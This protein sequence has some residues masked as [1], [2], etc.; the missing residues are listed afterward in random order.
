MKFKTN[1]KLKIKGNARSPGAPVQRKPV[2]RWASALQYADLGLAVVPVWGIKNDRCACANRGCHRP[3]K[4]PQ[5]EH[6]VKDATKNRAR[7]KAAWTKSPRSN[8]GVA[9]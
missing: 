5:T 6:G 1:T 3:G 8:I 2:N 4:H 7:I 9:T